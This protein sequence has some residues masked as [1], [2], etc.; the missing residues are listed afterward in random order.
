MLRFPSLPASPRLRT[1]VCVVF[2]LLL[3]F[4]LYLPVTLGGKTLLPVDNLFQYEPYRSTPAGNELTAQNGQVQLQN[5]LASDLILQ[6]YAW[7]GFIRDSLR[8]GELPLWNPYLFGGVPFLAAGQNSALYP[9]SVLFLL[10]PLSTAYG[11]FMVSQLALAGLSMYALIR[12][13]GL[14]R[15]SAVFAG[16]AFQLCGLLVIGVVHPMIVAAVAWQPLILALVDKLLRQDAGIG[17]R[18]AS[19]PWAVLGAA[20]VGC[21]LLAGHVEISVYTALVTAAYALWR[22]ATS[23]RLRERNYAISRIGWLA[24]FGGGGALL[25]AIQLLP[26]FELVTQNFRASGHSTLDQV[27]SYA[28]PVRYVALWLLPNIY[29]SWGHHAYFDWFSLRMEPAASLQGTWWGYAAKEQVESSVYAG[30]ATVLFAI[31]GAV[32]ALRGRAERRTPALFFVALAAASVL[33]IFGTRAYAILFY[34]L[35]GIDQL[36]SPFRW[37]FP[38][39]VAL[40]VLAALGFESWTTR[41]TVPTMSRIRHALALA[42]T[43]AGALVLIGIVAARMAWPLVHG[44][45]AALFEESVL[46]PQ[47]F[48]APE[49]LFSYI[50]DNAAIFGLLLLT[51]GVLA[52]LR[53]SRTQAV[54]LIALLAFDLNIA[55]V[56]F[57]PAVD[58]ALLNVQPAALQPLQ[59]DA[60]AVGTLK[61]WRVTSYEPNGATHNKPA[62]ANM[63]WPLKLQDIRGYDSI[64]PRRYV[65]YMRAIEPQNDLLYNRVSPLRERASLESPLLDM[66][67]VKYVLTENSIDVAGYEELPRVGGLRIYRNTRAMPRAYLMPAAATIAPAQAERDGAW[68]AQAI[69]SFDPRRFVLVN[70]PIVCG[71]AGCPSAAAV[72]AQ[73]QPAT[74]TAYANSEVWIDAQTG[75]G[76][77]WLILNDSWFPGWR[78]FVRPQGA[79]DDAEVEVPIVLVNG[80]FRG[81]QLDHARLPDGTKVATVR[82]KYSPDSVRYGAFTTVLALVS[83]LFTAGIYGWRSLAASNE[84]LSGAGRV[85]RNSAVLSAM[86]IVAR[87]I[88]FAFAIVVAR[89][90][91]PDG[92]GAYYFAVVV[93]SWFEIVLNFGLNTYLTREVARDRAHAGAYFRHT[94]A[95][96]L[97]L[98]AGTAPVF[99]LVLLGGRSIGYFNDQVALTI[100]ILGGSQVISSLNSGLSAL[101]FAYERGEVPAALSVISALATATIGAALLMLGWGVPALAITSVVVNI[102]TMAMLA[103]MARSQLNLNF[104]RSTDGFAVHTS[105]RDMLREAT[106]LMLNHLLASIEFKLD[107]PILKAAT[108]A[109][110]LFGTEAAGI[111]SEKV[112]GWYSTGYRFIDAFN[113]IPSFFTQSLFP[114]LSRMASQGSDA[115][116]RAFTLA[117]KLLVIVALPLAIA[118]TLLS[119]TLAGFFGAEF[120][121]HGAVA[122]SILSWSMIAGWINSVTN[123]ALI[124]VNQQR[125]ITRAFAVTLI[126]NLAANLLLVPLFSYQAAAVI[127]IGSEIIKGAIFYYYVRR[128]IG[129]LPWSAVLARPALAAGAM[130]LIG[131]G[132][133]WLGHVWL[134]VAAGGAAYVGM[135][136]LLRVFDAQERAVLAPLLR[137]RNLSK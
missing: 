46:A 32:T 43:L 6:N 7:K 117:V 23:G 77:E 24:I 127:T 84:T 81:V 130:A 28:F 107:V 47:R 30:L 128:H 121:P 66:L 34:G 48:A 99:M 86:N 115:F 37:K 78:A 11:W 106:P 41:T 108:P 3:P 82:F 33:F 111:A 63:L 56:G 85:A 49:G 109:V 67:G 131:G 112:V 61:L 75:P 125:T 120:L 50:A 95:L 110:A 29:G 72:P 40:C 98:S 122:I 18:P 54:A 35:P 45:M 62:N 16:V 10:L 42:T 4:A 36:H 64:I 93:V 79:A 12:T 73:Y 27:R 137:Q 101:F 119:E 21:H 51:N 89:L 69:R 91:G 102:L 132:G 57:A 104:G 135:L 100:A 31:V 68:F 65:E 90:L 103:V 94:T 60:D 44:P 70:D 2:L 80:N 96:R 123:Y 71:A 9:F 8:A 133:M 126:F 105:R 53:P 38:L 74:I 13:Y 39:T 134:G 118:T 14:R 87:L 83:L 114:A 136:L 15:S 17:G 124:A 25:A 55:W 88:S 19:L 97:L 52:G 92:V 26:L 1:L 58:P 76:R 129:V 22:L 20:A 113:I 59:N 116:M 5:E